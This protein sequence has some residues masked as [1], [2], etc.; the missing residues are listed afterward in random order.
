MNISQQELKRLINTAPRWVP[1]I[2]VPQKFITPDGTT[3]LFLPPDTYSWGGISTEGD[4]NVHYFS[5]GTTHLPQ[6]S[7]VRDLSARKWQVLPSLR[8]T[9]FEDCNI[10]QIIISNDC[11]VIWKSSTGVPCPPIMVIPKESISV[12][13][14]I[15]TAMV[16]AV[17]T[18]MCM[19]L[20]R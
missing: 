5:T 1:N 7:T 9:I 10:Q 6:T 15:T 17:L 3:T 20:F 11:R 8:E 19:W 16:V 4:L 14:V 12:A 18:M 13:V 2:T